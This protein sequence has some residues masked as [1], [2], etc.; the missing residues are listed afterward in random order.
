MP[1]ANNS[2]TDVTQTTNGT[3]TPPGDG[4]GTGTNPKDST[5]DTSIAAALTAAGDAAKPAPSAEGDQPKPGE[6]PPKDAP[7]PSGAPEKYEAWKVPEGYELDTGLSEEVNPIFKELGLTQEQAQKLVDFYSKHSIKSAEDMQKAGNEAFWALRREWRDSLLKDPETGKLTGKD[8][9][10]GPD[11]PLISTISKALDGL[12]NP[13]L[14]TD[15]KAAMEL[16]G[17]GDNPAFVKV[18]HALAKQV[19]EGDSY[20]GGGKPLDQSKRPTSAAAAIFPHLPSQS[21]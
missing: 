8:G 3:G 10:H 2:S 16:T 17:A 4:P 5:N 1:G 19:T 6:T 18:L 20:A 12:Q 15:F 11:S 21:G 7:K 9:K 13:K 14:V